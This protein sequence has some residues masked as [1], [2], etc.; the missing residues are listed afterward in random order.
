MFR[1]SDVSRSSIMFGLG[2]LYCIVRSSDTKVI[3]TYSATISSIVLPVLIAPER[4]VFA[5]TS[6]VISRYKC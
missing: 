5:N 1:H 2:T 4:R 3:K 6:G